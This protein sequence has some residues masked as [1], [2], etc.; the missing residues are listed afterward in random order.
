MAK[1]HLTP[2]E[3]DTIRSVCDDVDPAHF[4]IYSERGGERTRRQEAYRRAYDKLQAL[5]AKHPEPAED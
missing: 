1:I 4:E 5:G 3:A 2:F